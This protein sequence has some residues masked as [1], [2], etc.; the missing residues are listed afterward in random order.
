[1]VV[2]TAF[3]L[4]RLD[5]REPFPYQ[6]VD[7]HDGA[8]RVVRVAML[9]VKAVGDGDESKAMKK[10]RGQNGGSKQGIV[11]V[12]VALLPS[13]SHRSNSSHFRRVRYMAK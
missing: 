9:T 10:K 1:M 12:R 5:V 2:D 6:V 13:V 3:L 4:R 7:G 8:G 11:G